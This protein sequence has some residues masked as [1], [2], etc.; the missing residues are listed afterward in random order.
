MNI[1]VPA[2]RLSSQRAGIL[3][4]LPEKNTDTIGVNYNT[5]Y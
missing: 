3:P 1:L 2:T 5:Y 4:S